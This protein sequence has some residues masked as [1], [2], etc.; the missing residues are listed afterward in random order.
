MDV[1]NGDVLAMVSSPTFD[2]NDFAQGISREKYAQLQELQAEKNRATFENYAPG[3]IF[4]TVV[5]LAALENGLNVNE[6]YHVEADP[7][8]PGKGCIYV[9][10]RK[11]DDQAAP[12]D[13]NF[14]RAFI[15]SS[16]SYFVNVGLTR[17]DI[18]NIIRVGRE[19]HLGERT[20]L[21][22]NQEARGNFPTEKQIHSGWTRW[23][24]RECVHRPRPG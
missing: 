23:R 8:R 14:K 13:Y 24:H 12:G 19:F 5:A 22:A 3:S 18:E 10:R 1:R 7:Q 15:H 9:G 16:N 20:G 2:P 6:I 21:F 17:T 11:I 4:K